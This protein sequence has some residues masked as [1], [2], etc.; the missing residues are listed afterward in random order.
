MARAAAQARCGLRTGGGRRRRGARH[1]RVRALH[2]G[3]A[4]REPRRG[5]GAARPAAV[6]CQAREGPGRGGPVRPRLHHPLSE[7]FKVPV[8]ARPWVNRRG[9]FLVRALMV[10]A[11]GAAL[12]RGASLVPATLLGREQRGSLSGKRPPVDLVGRAWVRIAQ[13]S[14][15]L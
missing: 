11:A 2:K 3:K 10:K 8:P 6:G 1:G 5:E 4:P 14:V 9:A 13:L 12:P 7:P 15:L